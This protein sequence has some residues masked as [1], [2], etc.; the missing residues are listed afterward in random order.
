MRIS[1]KKVSFIMFCALFISMSEAQ[2][3]C[4]PED[5]YRLALE[6]LQTTQDLLRTE[7]EA[8]NKAIKELKS[9]EVNIHSTAPVGAILAWH[10]SKEGTPGL[11][12]GWVECNG[13]PIFDEDS[14]FYQK[15][16]P[17]LN[18]RALFLRG[19]NSS[20]GEQEQ[21]WKS[22][23]VTGTQNGLPYK[24]SAVL[25]PKTGLNSEYIYGGSWGIGQP[26][27]L[28]IKFDTSSEVRPKNMSVVWIMRIK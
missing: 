2:S 6:K 18:G 15:N 11:P 4:K 14:P 10:K 5:C 13:T 25:I 8:L 1:S 23:Y 22:F 27:S 17:N 3:S 28:Q 19:G 20:G 26:N 21:D 9:R 7:R 16:T 24:H 12:D